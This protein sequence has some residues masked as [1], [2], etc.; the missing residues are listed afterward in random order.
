MG[1]G[2]AFGKNSHEF[3]GNSIGERIIDYS[4]FDDFS[5]ER[6]MGKLFKL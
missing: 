3:F 1:L 6:Y 4:F 2:Y 5:D